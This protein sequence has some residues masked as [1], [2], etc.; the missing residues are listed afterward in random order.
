MGSHS[1]VLFLSQNP[2]ACEADGRSMRGSCLMPLKRTHRT[3]VPLADWYI[4]QH[5]I[6][7]SLQLWVDLSSPS[8]GCKSL[9]VV[10]LYALSPRLLVLQVRCSPR[11]TPCAAGTTYYLVL[12]ACMHAFPARDV[13]SDFRCFSRQQSLRHLSHRVT[14]LQHAIHPVLFVSDFT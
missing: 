5:T 14:P 4:I 1:F 2:G 3:H 11:C 9:V 12:R 13:F 7:L 6:T 8:Y 10:H